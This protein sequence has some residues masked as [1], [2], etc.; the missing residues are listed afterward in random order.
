MI[1]PVQRLLVY[2]ESPQLF[3]KGYQRS[4]NTKKLFNSIQVD[5]IKNLANRQT[6]KHFYSMESVEI[7]FELRLFCQNLF[8]LF[9]LPHCWVKL[10]FSF[11]ELGKS[12]VGYS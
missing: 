7:T 3:R 5:V 1:V 9:Q 6:G 4:L 2:T 10:Y 11:P 12:F 8:G